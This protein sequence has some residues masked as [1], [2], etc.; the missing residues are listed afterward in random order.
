MCL[1]HHWL[2]LSLSVSSLA[3]MYHLCPSAIFSSTH[4]LLH[5]SVSVVQLVPFLFLPH[6]QSFS[7]YFCFSSLFICL[8]F[9]CGTFRNKV[10]RVCLTNIQHKKISDFT[11]T[12]ASTHQDSHVNENLLNLLMINHSICILIFFF[13]TA[14]SLTA[15]YIIITLYISALI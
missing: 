1:I 8:L 12:E 11:R 7:H 10:C 15:L 14:Y 4:L 5:K 13:K 9:L 3:L 6:S 2:F